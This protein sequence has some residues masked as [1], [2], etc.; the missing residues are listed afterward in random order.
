MFGSAIH[1][2][3]NHIPITGVLIGL[4]VLIAGLIF[5][6]E[7]V[8]ITALAIFIFTGLIAI[9]AYLTGEGAES[10]AKTEGNYSETMLH[11]HEERSLFFVVTVLLLSVVAVITCVFHLRKKKLLAIM[12]FL[13]LVLA[14]IAVASGIYVSKTGRQIHHPEIRNSNEVIDV[15][16][17]S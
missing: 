2:V 9:L 13:T 15:Q 1:L 4:L 3:F 10:L 6:K 7:Q 11:I 14:T 16:S 12:H 5:R 17:D 8:N